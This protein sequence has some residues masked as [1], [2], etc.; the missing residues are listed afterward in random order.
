MGEL[1]DLWFIAPRYFS[2]D[3]DEIS[4]TI[5]TGMFETDNDE[6]NELVMLFTSERRATAYARRTRMP[7]HYMPLVTS[8]RE[9]AAAI[10]EGLLAHGRI[11]AAIDPD[12]TSWDELSIADLLDH[13]RGSEPS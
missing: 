3:A 1:T 9:E 2:G 4:K 6:P 12:A 7:A 5:L 11:T 8:N 13:F 10:L